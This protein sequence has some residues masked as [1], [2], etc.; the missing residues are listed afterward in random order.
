MAVQGERLRQPIDALAM[1]AKQACVS[2]SKPGSRS[3]G[4]FHDY[5]GRRLVKPGRMPRS[6]H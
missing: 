2:A 4:R 1:S 5:C 6:N 3:L